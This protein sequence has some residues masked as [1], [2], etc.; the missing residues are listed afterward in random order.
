MVTQLTTTSGTTLIMRARWQKI[1]YSCTP[2]KPSSS[3]CKPNG[4]IP[5]A[6]KLAIALWRTGQQ[7]L[8]NTWAND[9][10]C[11]ADSVRL[12]TRSRRETQTW[13][14]CRSCKSFTNKSGSIRLTQEA[15][16]NTTS[17]H[18]VNMQSHRFGNRLMSDWTSS[19]DRCHC[20]NA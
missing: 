11:I 15:Y 1:Y 8:T 3:F 2:P 18:H 13:C 14:K 7:Q 9:Y 6:C 4:F 5:N 19:R 10:T 16:W 20:G 12:I 17:R